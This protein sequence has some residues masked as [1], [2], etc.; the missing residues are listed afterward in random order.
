MLKSKL[1]VLLTVLSSPTL[2][3]AT[4]QID[5]K[6]P[7][8][9][10]AQRKT[11]TELNPVHGDTAIIETG[12]N[13]VAVQLTGDEPYANAKLIWSK[14]SRR[15]ASFH[16]DHHLGATRIFFRNGSTF[17][18]IKMPELAPPQLP[19]LPKADAGE[20]MRRV[21]PIRWT[22]SG[23][24]FLEDEMQNKA[25]ARAANEITIGFDD[26]HRASIRKSAPEKMSILDYFLLLPANTLE[27]PAYEWLQVMRANGNVIDKE[28]GYMS[29][30]G[31]GAQ[32]EYEVA[33][34]RYRDGRPLLALCN[35]EL[36]GDDA[37]FLHFFELGADGKM[38]AVSRPILP[39]PDLKADSES[40]YTKDGW[41]FDL[42]RHG[43]TIAA[44]SQKTKK[45]L[46]K[47]TWDGEKFQEDK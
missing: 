21:E 31:D 28:N 34:F 38:H 45:I 9:K 30:P 46:R 15:V 27:N 39:S 29:C 35:G 41:Q 44:R 47:F 3:R 33:L 14:D 20:T 11:M 37:V 5:Y 24:L 43:R 2:L 12:T 18:E 8:G 17:D 26:N 19:E 13:K 42:P 6:S 36:E 7:D 32:P 40:A 22:E 4:E 25:G 10:F 1:L 23:D 16:D